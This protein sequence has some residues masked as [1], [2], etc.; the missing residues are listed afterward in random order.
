[1]HQNTR[2]HWRLLAS[3][4]AVVMAAALAACGSD[5]SGAAADGSIKFGLNFAP[6]PVGEWSGIVVA[7][8]AGLYEDAGLDVSFTNLA[9]SADVVKAVGTG[10]LDVAF[11]S[12]DSFLVGVSQGLPIV[13][14]ANVVPR[15]YTGVIAPESSGITSIADLD[16]K[17]V[18]T[19]QASPE[20]LLLQALAGDAKPTLIYVEPQSKCTLMQSGESDACTGAA[21]FQVPT[22]EM[23]GDEVT[24]IPFDSADTPII[25]P[26]IIAGK[27]VV[28]DRAD[29]L[30]K[31]LAAT[32]DG[33]EQAYSDIPA[34]LDEYK[35]AFPDIDVANGFLE[36]AIEKTEPFLSR[37]DTTA[38][39]GWGQMSD[40]LWNS[41]AT[42]LY[43]G[44]MLTKEIEPGDAYTNDLLPSG[45]WSLPQ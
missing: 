38:G 30:E 34:A 20:P 16:G 33:Y 45:D 22:L 23:A 36:Q 41:L 31:L 37:P 13:A 11:A 44:D 10:Q 26:V 40:D 42:V 32:A 12:A 2:P 1:M 24:F 6:A 21:N 19:A 15:G 3:T 7:K 35:A 18:T 43:E 5:D 4:L 29:E 39:A 25:G 14:I 17:K 28:E 8:E 9:G 27:D